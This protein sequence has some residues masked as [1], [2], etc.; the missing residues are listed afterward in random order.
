MPWNSDGVVFG[1]RIY[2]FPCEVCFAAA[3]G[4][5]E[6]SLGRPE[7]IDPQIRALNAGLNGRPIVIFRRSART[8]IDAGNRLEEIRH[9]PNC[10]T[11]QGRD[12]EILCKTEEKHFDYELYNIEGGKI[13]SVFHFNISESFDR[14]IHSVFYTWDE[15]FYTRVFW[16]IEKKSDE[17]FIE[18]T[19]VALIEARRFIERY[20]V[21]RSTGEVE[22]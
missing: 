5:A 12:F 9:D 22:Q 3:V 15:W 16:L 6:L 4:Y 14:T 7:V 20:S 17:E 10:N 13:D 8:K 1:S 2:K 11:H 21:E 18:K 19:R